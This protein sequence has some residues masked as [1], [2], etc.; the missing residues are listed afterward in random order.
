MATVTHAR[1]CHLCEANC[2]ILVE[3]DGRTVKS[4]R[5]NPDHV[6]SHGYICPKATAIADIQDDPDRLRR[7]LKKL[8]GGWQEVSWDEAFA[9][10]A[11]RVTAIRASGKIAATYLGNPLTHN[12]GFTTQA[13]AFKKALGLRAFYSAS[14]LDQLPHMIVQKWVYGHFGIYPVP[15]LERTN[16]MVIVGGNPLAS[17]GSLWTSPNIRGQIKDLKARGGRLVV[18]DP[19]RTETAQLASD[20]HFIYPGTDTAFFLAV[21]LSLRAQGLVDP[22][23]LSEMLD[24]GWSLAWEKFAEFDAAVLSGQCGI[25]QEVIDDI[26]HGLAAGPAIMYGRMGVSVTQF[27]TLNHYLIQMINIATGNLDREGGVMLPRP[28]IDPV[29]NAGSGAYGRFKSRISG[30]PEVL[31]ELPAAELAPEI[32]TPG[33]GQIG[34]LFVVAGNPVLSAPGGR[35]LDAA[36]GVLDLMVSVDMYVTETSRHADYILPPCGPLEKDHYPMLL[37]PIAARNFAAYGP[38]AFQPEEGSKSDWEIIAE[39]TRAITKASGEHIPNG[40]P[41]RSALDHMLRANT[42]YNFTLEKL[43]QAPNGI[44]LGAHTPQLP[45]RLRTADGLI[46]CAPEHCIADLD[47]FRDSLND[48]RA[49]IVLIGRRH[50][51]SNN[52]WL[53]NSRRLIKGPNRCTLMINPADARAHNIGNEDMVR[54]F[55][56]VGDV[57]LPAE[58]TDDVMPG[59]VC[60][61]HG[62]G[63]GR[64]GVKLAVAAERPGVSIND[65]TDPALLDPLSGNAVL[66]GVPVQ[67]ERAEIRAA[68]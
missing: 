10:I 36:L 61:P 66:N 34:A 15:D 53:H 6:L 32:T 18:I 64:E 9:D 37:A 46:N 2:G 52:S 50:V 12:Y 54:V 60:I 35:G 22:G 19:R 30:Q 42:D 39:L 41:P 13:G 57:Q 25:S 4:I 1:T 33:E 59:V 63:H 51:R 14:T 8:R 44:D 40:P 58:I 45:E 17:N 24:D 68:S 48:A 56:H 20:H 28:V 65:L 11:K 7:P 47:R 21:L 31:G 29:V 5:G 55:N 27:G 23:R 3:L 38:A 26:A 62:Y 16:M 49:P 67:I 43:E